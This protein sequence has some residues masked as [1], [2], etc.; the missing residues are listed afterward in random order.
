MLRV[1]GSGFWVQK[2]DS[3]ISGLDLGRRD[4]ESEFLGLGS[5]FMVV[6]CFEFRVPGLFGDIRRHYAGSR[7]REF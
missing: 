6:L 1:A 4:Q 3:R 7:M 5:G 2:F